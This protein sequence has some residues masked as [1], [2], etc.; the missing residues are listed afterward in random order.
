MQTNEKTIALYCR[1]ALAD[2]DAIERQEERLLAYADEIIGASSI[3]YR[4]NGESGL[5]LDRPAMKELIADMRA[6]KVNF[7]VVT[8]VSRI[9]RSLAPMMEWQ[10]LSSRYGVKCVALDPTPHDIGGLWTAARDFDAAFTARTT[11]CTRRETRRRI[12]YHPITTATADRGKTSDMPEITYTRRGDYLLPN[13][14]LNEPP[15]EITLPLGGYGHRRRAFLKEHHP[16]L[17]SQMLLSETLYPHLREIDEA[18]AYRLAAIADREQA[19][20][21]VGE[22]IYE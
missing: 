10:A 6:G 13:L 3:F 14:I 11:P 17:Y 7:V 18:A 1:A 12:T 5:T 8:N 22:L 9:A 16:A 4:D 2:A 15:Q 21:I 19:K 20:E